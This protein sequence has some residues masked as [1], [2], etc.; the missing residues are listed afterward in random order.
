MG[1][2]ILVGVGGAYSFP[3]LWQRKCLDLEDERGQHL[4]WRCDKSC[5]GSKQNK[6][7]G[8][9]GL[10]SR[11]VLGLYCVLL[12]LIPPC[13]CQDLAEVAACIP[14]AGVCEA[15]GKPGFPTAGIVL[16]GPSAVCVGLAVSLP[17]TIYADTELGTQISEDYFPEGKVFF[18][19]FLF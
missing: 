8:N 9:L 17:G 11:S 13:S 1:G 2:A 19:F 4:Q 15:G 12:L 3:K 7:L 14:P 5:M 6:P 18:I 16:L 10:A